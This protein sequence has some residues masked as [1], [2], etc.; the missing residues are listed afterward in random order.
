MFT[1]EAFFDVFGCV[2][3]WQLFAQSCLRTL[4]VAVR[5]VPEALWMEWSRTLSQ[6]GT[7]TGNQETALEEIYDQ[8]EK[9][10]TVLKGS[11][12]ET[13][14]VSGVNCRTADYRKHSI[15]L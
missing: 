9:D 11:Y 15:L 1:Y 7:S 2:C 8:M 3:G 13:L 12:Y 4:C 14:I 6:V 10:L 5:S